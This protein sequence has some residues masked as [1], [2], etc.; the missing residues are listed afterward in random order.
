MSGFMMNDLGWLCLRKIFFLIIQNLLNKA[1]KSKK[2]EKVLLKD[3][4]HLVKT[5]K[6]SSLKAVKEYLVE[7]KEIAVE[8]AKDKKVITS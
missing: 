8:L 2:V 1:Y 7:G 6:R 4:R 3:L 5:Q